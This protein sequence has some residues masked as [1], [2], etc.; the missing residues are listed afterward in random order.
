MKAIERIDETILLAGPPAYPQTQYRTAL[1]SVAVSSI[2]GLA[3]QRR[4]L[5]ASAAT[6]VVAA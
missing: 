3:T 4:F 6:R 5:R 2:I 1:L